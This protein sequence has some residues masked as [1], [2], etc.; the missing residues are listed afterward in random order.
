MSAPIVISPLKFI[1]AQVPDLPNEGK[2][3]TNEQLVAYSQATAMYVMARRLAN[4]GDGLA[5]QR[6]AQS[7]L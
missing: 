1:K 3:A 2:N 4:R 6:I 5:V 7:M